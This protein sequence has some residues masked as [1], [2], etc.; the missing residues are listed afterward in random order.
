MSTI[1]DISIRRTISHIQ[2]KLHEVICA[3]TTIGEMLWPDSAKQRIKE[4]TDD[5]MRSLKDRG[6]ITDSESTCERICSVVLNDTPRG[7]VAN[8]LNEKGELVKTVKYSG[9]RYA[10]K[11]M[12][13]QIGLY[14][15][16]WKIE[17]KPMQVYQI[18]V[19][20]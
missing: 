4:V 10:R 3:N 12:R 8:C 19:S 15:I 11:R 20:I 2:N 16:A 1:D 17:P 13:R 5:F 7:P 9:R 6:A 18:R 14:V